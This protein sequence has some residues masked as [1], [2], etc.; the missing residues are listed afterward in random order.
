MVNNQPV[1]IWKSIY[2]ACA[3]YPEFVIEV[4]EYSQ[5]KEISEQQ[6]KWWKGVLLPAL[7]KDNGETIHVWETRLKLVILP[8]DF[9]PQS[10]VISGREYFFVPSITTLSMKKFNTL[11]EGSVDWL[12]NNGFDWVTLP[13]TELR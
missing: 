2:D 7:A 12:R 1:T 8:D 9:V 4:R 3:R 13:D 11:I 6:R 5:E 10:T